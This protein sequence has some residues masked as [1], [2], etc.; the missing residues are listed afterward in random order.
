MANLSKVIYINE[1]DYSTLVGG[2]TIT[3]NGTTYSY[4]ST[5]LYV[6]KNVG[7]PEYANTAGY[8]NSAGR[9]TGD[10]SGN[11]IRETYA[12]K[13]ELAEKISIYYYNTVTEMESSS[14]HSMGDIAFE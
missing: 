12:T 14:N 13:T 10:S 5:A 11:D 2:D 6:I 9:A 3:K 7:P 8:A 1:E 4:D